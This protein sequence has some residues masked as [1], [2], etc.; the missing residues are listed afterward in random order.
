M[1]VYKYIHTKKI[2]ATMH[3]FMDVLKQQSSGSV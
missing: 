2:D 3:G 1:D